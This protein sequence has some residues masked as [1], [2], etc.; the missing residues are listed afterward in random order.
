MCY[1]IR[2]S[3]LPLPLT[4]TLAPFRD[5]TLGRGGGAASSPGGAGRLLALRGGKVGVLSEFTKKG[6]SFIIIFIYV[7]ICCVV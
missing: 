4:S 7:V 6:R 3:L 5:P 1:S 2:F